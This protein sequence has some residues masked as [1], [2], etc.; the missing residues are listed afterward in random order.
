MGDWTKSERRGAV[1]ETHEGILVGDGEVDEWKA[2]SMPL[3]KAAVL[4][5]N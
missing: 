3:R 2:E 5:L 1:E 4:G